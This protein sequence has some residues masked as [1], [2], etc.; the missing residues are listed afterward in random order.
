MTSPLDPAFC[1]TGESEWCTGL[2]S[3][4]TMAVVPLM[5]GCWLT[6]VF[7]G[8]VRERFGNHT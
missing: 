4:P 8:W 1:I 7:G 5:A 3:T 6:G 2:P